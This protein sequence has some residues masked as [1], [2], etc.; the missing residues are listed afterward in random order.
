[1]V[2]ETVIYDGLG[3]AV[4]ASLIDG[5]L[6][7]LKS[8]KESKY[9]TALMANADSTSARNIISSC[10]LQEYFDA[11]L[12]SGEFGA[13]KRDQRIFQ[14]AL[15]RLQSNL[16]MRLWLAKLLAL[17]LSEQTGLE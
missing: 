17:T 11:I 9:N 3:K 7:V 16:R 13:E 6:E 1:M 10:G 2:E 12:S 14:V 4:T 15:D 8:I 5:V